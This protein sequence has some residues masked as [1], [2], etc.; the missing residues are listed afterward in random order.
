MDRHDLWSPPGVDSGSFIHYL[1]CTHRHKQFQLTE[2]TL[3]TANNRNYTI[4]T[5]K[6]LESAPLLSKYRQQK[7]EHAIPVSFKEN[8]FTLSKER[9]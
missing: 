4:F 5:L 9:L 3:S 6:S 2:G 8:M 7:V 1:Q